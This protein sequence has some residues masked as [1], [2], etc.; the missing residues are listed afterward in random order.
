MITRT[1]MR[2]PS[3]LIKSSFLSHN[4]VSNY[5]SLY[6]R[7]TKNDDLDL[8][9]C[10][11]DLG[12]DFKFE[13]KCFEYF[14][15][16]D[17]APDSWKIN[18][19]TDGSAYS[20]GQEGAKGGYGVFFGCKEYAQLSLRFSLP[21]TE[22]QTNNVAELMAIRDAIQVSSVISYIAEIC[23]YSDSKYS[24]D[25]ITKKK[26]SHANKELVVQIQKL[27]KSCKLKVQLV[28]VPAHTGKNDIHSVGNSIADY[29]ASTT[30]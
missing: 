26:K 5:K 10:K 13:K 22:K 30:W 1:L 14:N 15:H 27:I 20:N 7:E 17:Y 21:H 6:M 12:V 29:L 18:V 4:F 3:S 28:H 19:Y 16:V 2:T 11:M 25:V 9:K 8:K 24:I 23:I